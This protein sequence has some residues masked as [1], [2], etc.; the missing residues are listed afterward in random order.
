MNK[1][2]KISIFVTGKLSQ[3]SLSLELMQQS[4]AKSL[5]RHIY[6]VLMPNLIV[7]SFK[8]INYLLFK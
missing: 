1:G 6:V 4:R 3:D 2:V 5:D 7:K 8:T